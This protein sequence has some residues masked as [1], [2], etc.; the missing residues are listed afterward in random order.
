MPTSES[1]GNRNLLSLLPLGFA[2]L[3]NLTSQLVQFALEPAELQRDDQHVD[4][5]DEEDDA[6][7]RCDVLFG[8]RHGKRHASSSRSSRRR[9]SIRFPASS[10][11][12]SVAA[13]VSIAAKETQ[14]VRNIEPAICGPCSVKTTGWM[15]WFASRIARKLIGISTTPKSA[16]TAQMFA[17]AGPG[18]IEYR[19]MK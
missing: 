9:E 7:R 17:R 1:S 15:S 8:S 2:S 11:W 6:V 12:K 19:S 13:R 16:Y 5:H 18:S 3:A 14:K 4:E 10:T